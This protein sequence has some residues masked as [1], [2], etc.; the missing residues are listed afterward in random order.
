MNQAPYELDPVRREAVLAAILE[1]C[2][3]RGWSLLAAHV[4]SNHLHTVVDAEASP[5]RV[6]HDFKT[7]ASGRLNRLGLEEASRK[8]WAR[9]GSTRWLGK[10]EHVS[11]AIRYAVVEQGDPMSVFEA[12]P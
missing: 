11:A 8:R 10:P 9:H 12:E 5:E 6:M 4:R 1:V 7:Y 3:R 2:A